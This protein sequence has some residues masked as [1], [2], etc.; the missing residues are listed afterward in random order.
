VKTVK[1][2]EAAL[3][4]TYSGPTKQ[5]QGSGG[6]MYTYIPWNETARALDEVFGVTGWSSRVVALEAHPES[7]V[8]TAAVEITGYAQAEDGTVITITRSGV[9]RGVA[10][11]SRDEQQ[12]TGRTVSSDL[13]IHDTAAATAGSDAFSRAAKLFGKRLG[14][15]LYD[16]GET[17]NAG[18]YAPRQATGGF[19]GQMSNPEGAPSEKQISFARS[20]GIDPTGMTKGQLSAAIDAAKSGGA[21]PKSTGRITSPADLLGANA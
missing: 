13:G 20:L 7:G 15:E 21:A 1:E 19:S 18:S 9:G 8:Y 12:A 11:A 2:V 3:N 4:E 16:K 6:K 14:L 17:Q 10:R 5:V